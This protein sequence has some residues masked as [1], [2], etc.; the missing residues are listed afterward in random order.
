MQRAKHLLLLLRR[1]LLLLRGLLLLQHGLQ[2]CQHIGAQPL[3]PL[4]H[5][6][7]AAS[8][9]LRQ[10]LLKQL[11]LTLLLL[12]L[13]GE[14]LL[15]ASL[16]QCGPGSGWEAARQPPQALQRRQGLQRSGGGRGHVVRA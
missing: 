12:L 14:L 5:P 9:R 10:Q 7:K 11:C 8:P 1:L 4:L 15:H 3:L 16:S 13:Q 6:A 2:A